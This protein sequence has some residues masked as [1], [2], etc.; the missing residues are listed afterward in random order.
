MNKKRSQRDSDGPAS[1]NSLDPASNGTETLKLLQVSSFDVFHT[2]IEKR[3]ESI[4][5]LAR[6]ALA[7]PVTAITGI[8]GDRQ[9]F[10]SVVGWAVAQLPV[11]ESLCRWTAEGDRVEI[12]PDLTADARSREH[13]LVVGK[14]GFKFYAG[15][16][17]RDASG[18]VIGTFCALDLKPR[19]FSAEDRNVF[20]DLTEFA[21]REL[22]SVEAGSAYAQLIAKLG[23]ARREA[24]L[25]PLTRLW[26]R[27]AAQ[28]LLNALL[29]RSEEEQV[30]LSVCLIDLDRFKAIN[31]G[32]GHHSGDRVL[33][34]IARRFVD[35]LRK[36]DVVCRLGG[37]EFL[38][39][40]PGANLQ[41]ATRA[42]ERLREAVSD[43]PVFLGAETPVHVTVSIG[44]ASRAPGDEMDSHAL[45]RAADEALMGSKGD[46]R[47]RVRLAG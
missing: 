30:D 14:P 9:W 32:H 16:P 19:R 18:A 47:N 31:D 39:I 1:R 36:D 13:P 27:R 42:A 10:K 24:M 15:S 38:G 7:V 26:N 43:V 25:D 5:R 44:C 45:L 17:L 41:Q 37:D 46:G 20:C 28:P 34:A 3:F 2:P 33:R 29:R 21:Q 6:R 12:I 23:V 8:A 11:A 40:L 4:T 35:S 22:Q